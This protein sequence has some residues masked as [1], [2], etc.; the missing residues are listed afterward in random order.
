MKLTSET[1]RQLLDQLG[2][3]HNHFTHPAVFTT[4]DV[5]LLPER[6]P[7]V[8]TKNLFLRDE[9]RRR[10]VLV[11]VRAET[12]VDLKQ[13]GRVLNMKGLTFASPEDLKEMLGVVP[14]SVC[15]FGLANDAQ[16][17]V[18][19]FID[20]SI[21]PEDE[22]QNHPLLNTETV[23]LRVSD[24]LRLCAHVRHPLTRVEIPERS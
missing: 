9:K 10:Y 7:G 4:A 15:L 23:V 22:M 18:E 21:N 14:G 19:G 20:S 6:L 5:L 13:L 17:R 16:G 8:D 12:R 24:M 3:P 11:C 1:L 2:I